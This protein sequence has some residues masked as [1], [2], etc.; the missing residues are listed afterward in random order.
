MDLQ[1]FDMT[2][3]DIMRHHLL[4]LARGEPFIAQSHPTRVSPPGFRKNGRPGQRPR[5]VSALR[6]A[7]FART[8]PTASLT[9]NVH[10]RART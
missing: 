6:P 7:S 2:H 8:A 9:Y 3:A 10:I 4:P 5:P 1:S